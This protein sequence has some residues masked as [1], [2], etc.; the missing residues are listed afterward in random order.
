M[1][2]KQIGKRLRELRG[3]R[4][5]QKVSDETGLGWSTICMYELGR[6]IPEDDNK[7]I[8]ARY[9]GTTVQAL[10]YDDDIAESNIMVNDNDA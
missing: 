10:F 7:V 5:I 1:D 6:R 9:Y 4:T 8:I 3:N 2:A